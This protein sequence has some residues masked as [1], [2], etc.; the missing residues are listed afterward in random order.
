M[1]E[2]RRLWLDAAKIL[3]ENP[4]AVVNCPECEKGKLKTKDEEIKEWDKIDRYLICDTCGRY[5]VLTMT[6][7]DNN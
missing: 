3:A 4:E 1:T 2:T 7:R 5:E 6:K